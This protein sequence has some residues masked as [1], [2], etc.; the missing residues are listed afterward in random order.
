M[1]LSFT[2]LKMR[3]NCHLLSKR[4]AH[5]KSIE[6]RLEK[7]QLQKIYSQQIKREGD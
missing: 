4:E 7:I 6:Q 1:C 3:N 5:K 2:V